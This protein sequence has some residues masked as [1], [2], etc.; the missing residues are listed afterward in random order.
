[1]HTLAHPGACPGPRQPHLGQPAGGR[2]HHSSCRVGA[3]NR[4]GNDVALVGAHA[5]PAAHFQH[6]GGCASPLEVRRQRDRGDGVGR[7]QL[8]R[9]A[10][11]HAVGGGACCCCATA[12]AAGAGRAAVV[13]RVQRSVC[14]H[15]RQT[16]ALHAVLR[17]IHAADRGQQR[18]RKDEAHSAITPLLVH[19][20]LS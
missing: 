16:R 11:W 9:Q 10:A 1:M 20:H 14:R 8:V 7:C 12:G 17:R 19:R 3:A 4:Q 5:R 6:R 15:G 18:G 13:Q 2:Q